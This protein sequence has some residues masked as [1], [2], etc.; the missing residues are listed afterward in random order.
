MYLLAVLDEQK[1]GH[2]A[3]GVLLSGVL[4]LVNVDLKIEKKAFY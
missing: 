1:C 3:N 2:G 4:S